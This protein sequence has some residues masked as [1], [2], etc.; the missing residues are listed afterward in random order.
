[1]RPKIQFHLLGWATLLL[2]PALG[3]IA[4]WYFKDI[5]VLEVLD[6]DS[7]SLPTTLLGL[8]FG[9]FYGGVVLLVSQAPFFSDMSVEQTRMLVRLNLNWGDI[10]F[11]SFCAAFGEEI[12]FRAGIQTWLGPWITSVL[13]IAIHGYLHPLSW[14]KSILGI[15]LLPFILVI[16]FAYETMGLWF[17]IAAHFAYDLLLFTGALNLKN[18][19]FL[20]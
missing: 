13:F 4:L 10:I 1:M 15:L 6:L 18:K 17:C 7:I 14:R 5:S 3:I 16:S 19:G 2:F 11:M 9:L 20:K 12:L 8:E